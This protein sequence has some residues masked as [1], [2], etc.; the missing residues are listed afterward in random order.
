MASE[1]NSA[2]DLEFS[3]A[4]VDRN[5][6]AG[7][8]PRPDSDPEPGPGPGT[9]PGPDSL[10][11]EAGSAATAAPSEAALLA[12]LTAAVR[13]VADLSRR[14]HAR[15]EQR[16]GVID[17]LRSEI[18]TLRRGE[19]RGLL[20]PV[21]TE[22]CRLRED[23]LSQAEAL[24]G[25][26]RRG[27][28]APICCAPTRRRSSSRWRTT[29]SSPTRPA[30]GEPFDPRLHRRVGGERRAD[31]ALAG[32][33]RRGS[34]AT[35]TWTSRRTARSRPPRSPSSRCG[36]PPAACHERAYPPHE[37]EQ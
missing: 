18:D 16:E 20:R 2:N 4:A 23:L 31:P 25:R 17:H 21:L 28:G 12:E 15:A 29:A 13:A 14:Y 24:P 34:G 19:R 32:H 9:D 3:Q 1:L 36:Q 10:T 8:T 5:D 26:L 30:A 33:D 35:A 27:E 37:G 11:A 22:M 7:E 6:P